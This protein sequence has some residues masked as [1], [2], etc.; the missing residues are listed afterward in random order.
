[1]ERA[2]RT[3]GELVYVSRTT[4]DVTPERLATMPAAERRWR[5]F[6]PMLRD[7]EVYARGF[8]RHPDHATIRLDGWHRVAMNTEQRARA[9]QHVVF[10]D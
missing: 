5:R 10:L 9:M 3:G 4:H 8:V 6:V 2:F 1:M 7:A